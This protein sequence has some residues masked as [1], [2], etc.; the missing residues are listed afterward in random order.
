VSRREYSHAGQQLGLL[1]D[2][3]H[4]NVN[5]IYAQYI[6]VDRKSV[7]RNLMGEI[8]CAP[9]GEPNKFRGDRTRRWCRFHD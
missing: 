2:R 5:I 7:P 4:S 1:E 8:S 6:H 3:L 9:C